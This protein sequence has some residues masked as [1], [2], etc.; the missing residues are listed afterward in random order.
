MHDSCS[1]H[2]APDASPERSHWNFGWL[3]TWASCGCFSSIP[4]W[5]KIVSL[6]RAGLEPRSFAHYTLTITTPPLP[7]QRLS[8]GLERRS[9]GHPSDMPTTLPPPSFNARSYLSST[10]YRRPPTPVF[11]SSTQVLPY[12]LPFIDVRESSLF[13][14]HRTFL[15]KIHRS[16]S[17][18]IPRHLLL[19][20][21]DCFCLCA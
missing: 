2:G 18:V 20:Y 15:R 6:Y 17:F 12:K 19:N 4:R 16:K 14:V 3:K 8:E 13:V 1:A 11:Y 21:R 10:V 5:L 7:L 9:F